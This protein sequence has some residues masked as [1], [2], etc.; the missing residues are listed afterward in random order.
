MTSEKVGK[1]SVKVKRSAIGLVL[2]GHGAEY[3][4]APP[5]TS[6]QYSLY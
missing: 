3:I 2:V 4:S 5:L 1:N 6:T